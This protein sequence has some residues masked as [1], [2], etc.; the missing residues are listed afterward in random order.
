MMACILVVAAHP[1]DEVLGCGGTLVKHTLA[2]DRVHIVFMADGETSRPSSTSEASARE[3]MAHQA[4]EVLGAQSLHFLGFPD[5]A[6]DSLP[7]LHI[8]QKLESIIQPLQPDTIYTHF[9]GDLNIDHR[10]TYQAV[11]TACRPQPESSVKKIYCFEVAS[12]TE[13]AS[14]IDVPFRPQRFVDISA[15]LA[16]KKRALDFYSKELRPWPHTR[17]EE[18][19]T[20]KAQ[21][22]GNQV[23]MSAAEAFMVERELC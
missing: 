5:N 18:A 7:L 2:G 16:Q 6:M 20:L 23:G 4:G 17:S 14:Q 22:R 10:L 13:W 11:M 19:I 1:D 21:V 3:R 12:S 9:G 8:T 15:V